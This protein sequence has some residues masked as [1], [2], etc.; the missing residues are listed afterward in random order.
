MTEQRVRKTKEQL[1][2]DAKAKVKKIEAEIK[3]ANKKKE[4][5][6]TKDSEGIAAAIEAISKAAD[7][8]KSTLAEVIKTISSLKRTGLKIKNAERKSKNQNDISE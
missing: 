7:A 1:L 8:N 5:K 2:E 3:A 6:L 4:T